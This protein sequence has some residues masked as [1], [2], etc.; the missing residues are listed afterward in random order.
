MCWINIGDGLM[1]TPRSS[2][3]RYVGL[4]R[5]TVPKSLRDNPC[6]S[7]SQLS[8]LPKVSVLR[9]FPHGTIRVDTGRQAIYCRHDMIVVAKETG[10]AKRRKRIAGICRDAATLGVSRQDLF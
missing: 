1:L 4:A 2:L 5:T 6:F 7:L 3:L 9:I 8:R 10:K